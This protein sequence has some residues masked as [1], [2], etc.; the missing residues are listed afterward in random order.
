MPVARVRTIKYQ[1]GH[2]EEIVGLYEDEIIPAAAEQ[3]GLLQYLLFN[4]PETGKVLS[5]TIWESEDVVPPGDPPHYVEGLARRLG[6]LR[7]PAAGTPPQEV[8]D[9][10]VDRKIEKPHG[11]R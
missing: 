4:D 5:I 3:P 1:T 6:E 7:D 8:F 10:A 9:V 2:D 11:D